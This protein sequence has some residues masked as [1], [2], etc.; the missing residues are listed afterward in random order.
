MENWLDKYGKGGNK[1]KRLR[2]MQMVGG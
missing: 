1:K 2:N